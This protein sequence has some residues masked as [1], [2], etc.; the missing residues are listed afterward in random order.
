M[1]IEEVGELMEALRDGTIE[2]AQVARLDQLL[3]EHPEAVE[4]FVDRAWLRADLDARLGGQ[5]A[6]MLPVTRTRSNRRVAFGLAAAA[7]LLVAL[8]LA[9]V[10]RPPRTEA[11]GLSYEGCAVL[12]K[13]LGTRWE[14]SGPAVG[15]VLP[16]GRLAFESGVIQVEFFSGARVILE[17]PADFEL[18]S[19]NEGLCRYGKLRAFVPPQAQG[20]TVRTSGITLVD[21][22]TEFGLRLDRS[23]DAEVHVFQGLVEIHAKGSRSELPVGRALRIDP[24]GFIRPIELADPE[25]FVTLSDLT[26]R[27]AEE[28]KS[29]FAQWSSASERL[30]Q[31]PRVAVYYSFADVPDW[32][33]ELR[34]Q[35]AARSPL[36]GAI[37]G[38]RWAEGRWPG[39]K[40]LEFKC[41]GDRVRFQDA[42]EYESLTLM[43]WVRVDALDR[44]FSGLMLTD[45]WTSGSVHWQ[46]TQHGTLRLG[47]HGDQQV[48]DYDTP[49]LFTSGQFG[50]WIHLCTVYNRDAREVLHYVDGRLANRLPLKFDTQLRLGAVELGNWGVPLQGNVYA[51]RNLNGRMDEFALFGK[52]LA[53]EEI[54]DLYQVGAPAP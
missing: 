24:A 7:V 32:S 44:L 8:L 11:V 13:A 52:A 22:G 18:L 40:A 29:R 53:A 33:R 26:L 51:V 49:V 31:D 42:G 1:N 46:I 10:T 9:L 30:R 20:F 43:T 37:I 5:P 41:P 21:R 16:K 2:G 45:G 35:R 3:A 14:G 25:T 27:S 47:I 38:C 54:R 4:Y 17:G 6:L 12:T 50:R 23:G 19:S 39:K 28:A 15:S 36:D 34:C 48:N